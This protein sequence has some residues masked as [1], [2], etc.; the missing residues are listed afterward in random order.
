MQQTVT[1]QE[2]SALEEEENK[3][4]NSIDS[5]T[6]EIKEATPLP[7]NMTGESP[8]ATNNATPN[9]EEFKD[10]HTSDISPK[11]E[12]HLNIQ[13]PATKEDTF[14]IQNS[15]SAEKKDESKED[16]KFISPVP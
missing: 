11:S 10:H 2:A 9:N 15:P 4:D 13:Q 7:D 16:I 6:H 12:L 5:K 3:Q 1:S 14:L 8:S